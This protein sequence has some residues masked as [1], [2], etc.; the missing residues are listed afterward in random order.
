MA[1]FLLLF[2]TVLLLLLVA[3][4]IL[5]VR[6]DGSGHLPPVPSHHRWDETGA[7]ISVTTLRD[8]QDRH[9]NVTYLPP[10]R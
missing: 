4:T 3:A 2:S 10:L 5:A 1:T 8:A 9:L 7:G 6:R